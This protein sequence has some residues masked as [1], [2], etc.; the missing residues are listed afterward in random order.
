MVSLTLKAL[1]KH[2]RGIQLPDDIIF[3]DILTRLPVQSLLRFWCVCKS[4]CYF[5]MHKNPSFID[6]HLSRS[7]SRFGATKL[8]LSAHDGKLHCY[9]MF[10]VDLEEGRVSQAVRVANERHR[11]TRRIFSGN[12]NGLVCWDQPGSRNN[13]CTYICNPSTRELMKLPM[14]PQIMNGSDMISPYLSSYL[15]FDPSSKEFK[16]L[17]IQVP[18]IKYGLYFWIFTLGGNSWRQIHPTLPYGLSDCEFQ[19]LVLLGQ[20][21]CLNGA[22]HWLLAYRKVIVVF[23]L[24]DEKFGVIPLPNT[25]ICPRTKRI[26]LLQ[27]DDR[28]L[29]LCLYTS[30]LKYNT[31][32]WTLEDYKNEVW[33]K[34]TFS[35]SPTLA[36]QWQHGTVCAVPTNIPTSLLELDELSGYKKRLVCYDAKH[37]SF[38]I[39]K[40]PELLERWYPN[41]VD[42]GLLAL[43]NMNHSLFPMGQAELDRASSF[44]NRRVLPL[45][46]SDFS[47]SVAGIN[48]PSL[49]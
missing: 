18:R 15:G 26:D 49:T 33:I 37:K 12:I 8:L 25:I 7:Q 13:N 43:M 11:M 41:S 30:V 4:W 21:Q 42:V 6:L 48:Q 32:V 29:V 31:E 3:Y 5:L 19:S 2:S 24:R 23:N 10:L 45:K 9:Y 47:N 28:L 35:I 27:V 38:L 16:V 44:P 22:L 39:V 40:I 36:W 1:E 46:E 14:T 34:D 20:C 17:K